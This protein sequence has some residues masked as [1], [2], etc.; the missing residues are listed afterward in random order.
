MPTLKTNIILLFLFTTMIFFS[1]KDDYSIEEDKITENIWT[2]EQRSIAIPNSPFFNASFV[3]DSL[4]ITP[5][6]NGILPAFEELREGFFYKYENITRVQNMESNMFYPAWNLAEPFFFVEEFTQ[7]YVPVY[8]LNQGELSSIMVMR[9]EESQPKYYLL[10]ESLISSIEENSPS[11]FSEYWRGVFDYF[12]G[13]L[14]G[15]RYEEVASGMQ[16]VCYQSTHTGWCNCTGPL[17]DLCGNFGVPPCDFGCGMIEG[18]P[19]GGGDGP[20]GGSGG[21][22]NDD[23]PPDIWIGGGIGFVEI[24]LISNDMGGGSS[25]GGSP[26]LPWVNNN[27]DPTWKIFIEGFDCNDEDGFLP[28]PDDPEG[29]G[30]FWEIGFDPPGGLLEFQLDLIITEFNLDFSAEELKDILKTDC[31][32]T[33]LAQVSALVKYKLIEFLSDKF[34]LTIA[35]KWALFENFEYFQAILN[36]FNSNSSLSLPSTMSN[37]QL[38]LEL[39]SHINVSYEI[40]AWILENEENFLVTLELLEFLEE[41]NSEIFLSWAEE[42]FY[43]LINNNINISDGGLKLSLIDAMW[44]DPE[45]DDFEQIEDVKNSSYLNRILVII[46]ILRYHG[47]DWF[48][49]FLEDIVTCNDFETS[50]DIYDTYRLAVDYVNE[51]NKTTRDAELVQWMEA[52]FSPENVGAVYG[53]AMFSNNL[54]KPYKSQ[55][56]SRFSFY[57]KN[58]AWDLSKG[59]NTMAAFKYHHGSAGPGKHWHHI[60]EKQAINSSGFAAKSVHHPNNLV[61]ISGGYSGSWHSK[62]TSAFSQKGRYENVTGPNMSLREWLVGK[63]FEEHYY[64]GLKVMRE[65]RPGL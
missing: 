46:E 2:S 14:T 18:D 7:Y 59:Y 5:R 3:A 53:I 34:Y 37:I 64:W 30:G 51:I 54:S 55:F 6:L 23:F 22:P 10:W 50:G 15:S 45:W 61:K 21:H 17:Q 26:G 32:L 60:V 13:E 42:A 43:F 11:L 29:G 49:N 31:G 48:P 65:V 27:D 39:N 41:N 35:E 56:F 16:S 62:I 24:N 19:P 9:Y 4:G 40:S 8:D 28:L 20:P 38:I 33:E 63:S 36:A 25:G 52:I 58:L 57:S 47:F 1:C 44:D 12:S